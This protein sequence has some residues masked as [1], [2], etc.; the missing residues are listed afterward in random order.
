MAECL[1]SITMKPA[2]RWEK[3]K[4]NRIC[5]CV[6]IIRPCNFSDNLPDALVC[7][8]C[9]EYAQ[10]KGFAPFNILLCK[11]SIIMN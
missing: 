8:G 11:K 5:Y 2:E 10:G 9:I 6:C 3:T 1:V 7:L 4:V